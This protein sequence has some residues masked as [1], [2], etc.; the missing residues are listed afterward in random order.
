MLGSVGWLSWKV[1]RMLA[2]EREQSRSPFTEKLI[3][4]PGES[5]RLQIEGLR[6]EIS[7]VGLRGILY[8][9]GPSVLLM[10]LRL[11]SKAIYFVIVGITFA[12]GW[13]LA[14]RE[15]QRLRKLRVDLRN[16]RLGFDGERF[17]AAELNGLLT[18]GYRVFHDFV[19]DWMLDDRT[20]NIDH[21]I[22][23]PA[24]VFALETKAWRKP[25]G[26]AQPQ[27]LQVTAEGIQKP[28]DIPRMDAIEQAKRNAATLSKWLTGNAPETVPVRPLVVVPGWYVVADDWR[29]CGVQTLSGLAGRLPGLTRSAGLSPREV[30]QLG[31]RIEAHCRT[32]NVAN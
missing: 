7:E 9:I 1:N 22:V 11:E 3:R 2:T 31:D 14:W 15:W 17:V 6:E 29:T 18:Q 27:K 16:A 10:V 32:A 26:P 25:I 8:L 12:I 23:G 5:L 19:V 13:A 28:G 30:Q 20:H 24:G 21:I 4:P